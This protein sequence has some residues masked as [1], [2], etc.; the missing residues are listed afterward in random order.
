MKN[1]T[2]RELIAK[3]V[4]CTNNLD[5]EVPVYFMLRD[6]NGCVVEKRRHGVWTYINGKLYI[7]E[8]NIKELV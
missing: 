1:M 5:D 6:S 3:I 4:T 8:P 2:A 7:E